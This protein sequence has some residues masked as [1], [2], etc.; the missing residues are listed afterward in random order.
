MDHDEQAIRRCLAGDREAF[1]GLVEQYKRPLYAVAFRLLGD[2]GLAEDAVQE[3]FLRAYRALGRFRLGEPLAPWLYR[4]A[5]NICHD[6]GRSRRRQIT[7]LGE[8]Q[9]NRIRDPGDLPEEAATRREAQLRVRRAVAELPEKYRLLVVLAHQQ[10]MTYEDICRVTG[11]PLTM[12]KN[13]LYRARQMLKEKL[14]PYYQEKAPAPVK[15]AAKGGVPAD[16]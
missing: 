11:E 4:I 1:A 13:R 9:V 8:E 12:V 10:G 7:D 2:S 6:L 3:T 16:L 14:A 5:T 15:T